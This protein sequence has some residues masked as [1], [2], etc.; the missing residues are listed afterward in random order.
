MQRP[1]APV[2]VVLAG[3]QSRRMQGQDKALALIGG[4]RMIDRV[5]DRLTPQAAKVLLCAPH[6]YG[7]GLECVPDLPTGPAGPAGAIRGA[8]LHLAAQG[9]DAF[10]TVPVDAPFLASDLVA[11]LAAHAPVAVVRTSGAWQPAFALW[12]ARAVIAQLSEDRC[13]EKWSLHR[14]A[15][16]TGAQPVEFADAI[17][18][19]NVNTPDELALAQRLAHDEAQVRAAP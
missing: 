7:T 16:A 1:P 10:V 12:S 19:M 9:Q 5:L 11:Q 14:L 15:E 4:Q 3:G 2:A 6:D 8:A 18:M 13:M 17:A